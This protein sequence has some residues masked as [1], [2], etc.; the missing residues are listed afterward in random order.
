[1]SNK[2]TIEELHYVQNE[3]KQKGKS[4]SISYLLLLTFGL[5]GI[6]LGY[7]ERTKSAILRS[8]LTILTVF[9]LY[10]ISK[11]LIEFN[12]VGVTTQ[13]QQYSSFF[14][15]I[16]CMMIGLN[17]IWTIYDLV[18]LPTMVKEMNSKIEEKLNFKV[19]EA[20]YV[21]EKIKREEISDL[22]VE[23]ISQ[24]ISSKLDSHIS[25]QE[26][27]VNEDLLKIEENLMDKR[28]EIL[29]LVDH[30]SLNLEQL[31]D[32]YSEF[33]SLSSEIKKSQE[34]KINSLKMDLEKEVS[35]IAKETEVKLKETEQSLNIKKENVDVE[36]LRKE[37]TSISLESNE[38]VLNVSEAL[39]KEKGV[40]S[41][42]GF[43]VGN[44][45][46]NRQRVFFDCFD[47]EMNVAI[48]QDP[49]ET[50]REK[51]I[52]VQL[53]WDSG[54]RHSVGLMSNK[55]NLNRPVIVKGE[56]VDY[57]KGSGLKNVVSVE[58]ID[59]K[60]KFLSNDIKK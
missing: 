34:E 49:N 21:K 7:L 5:V 48:A 26:N 9:L 36:K 59:T 31:K 35:K 58:F 14:L 56:L 19:L 54:L 52:I 55:N 25:K 28:G 20:R 6:H 38:E 13:L 10:P 41:I 22:L 33:D 57:F 46:P 16:A 1:M 27:K 12:S 51:M 3:V 17:V 44:M 39:G 30:V 43:I 11:I 32:L 2:L 15:V 50:D 8:I 24:S 18:S 40:Y 53:T 47:N 23:E 42:K 4:L 45:S 60:D 29:D 37:V